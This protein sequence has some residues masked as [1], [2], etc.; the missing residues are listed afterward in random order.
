MSLAVKAGEFCYP[1]TARSILNNVNFQ[2]LSGELLAILGPNGAGKTT[3]LK[4]MIGLHQWTKG[5]TFLHGI[6]LKN[7][8][9]REIG[10]A[11]SYVPQAKSAAPLSLSGIE[12]VELG[13]APKLGTFAQ[14]GKQ[15]R[16]LAWQALERVGATGLANLP[17]GQMSG[18]QFQMVLIA[19]ALV[20]NPQVLVLDEPE[21]GLDFR[22]QLIVLELLR[23]LAD[24]GLMVV[25]NTHYPSHAL[26]ISDKTILIGKDHS[27]RFG[28]TKTLL[29]EKT[30]SKL[31]DV[32]IA[33]AQIN[34]G[35]K[36]LKVVAPIGLIGS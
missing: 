36:T 22:N 32:E 8:S 14:P 20:T 29:T 12:M 2:L 33:V 27:I 7:L 26:R 9:I 11:I 25:M 15:E 3:L 13:L 30:L 23:H 1:G 6:A 35:V 17:C 18:G 24:S 31:F 10:C 21:T 34:S 4:A 28:E 19:R 16:N 5:E